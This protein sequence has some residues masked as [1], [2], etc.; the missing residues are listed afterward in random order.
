MFFRLIVSVK[1]LKAW[2]KQSISDCSSCWLWAANAA[3]STNSMSL[4]R[5]SR[6]FVVAVRQAGLKSLPSFLVCREISSVVVPKS[7]FRSREKKI[8]KEEGA[9]MQPCLTPLQ[10]LKGS[11]GLPLNC[12]V[13]VEGFNHAL[14]FGGQR[15]FGTALK[16][17]SLL[18]RS[19][20]LMTL[21]KATY[22]SICCFLHSSWSWRREKTMPTVDLSTPKLKRV[23]SLASL[24]SRGTTS[25]C[26]HW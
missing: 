2:E 5:A 6:N 15:I 22:R 7:C 10:M 12:T 11:E 25:S 16:R 9:R 1:S 14:Q 3:S 24:L 13:G 18:T 23:T 4:M 17:P 20:P 26:Q 8:P 21:M 19:N